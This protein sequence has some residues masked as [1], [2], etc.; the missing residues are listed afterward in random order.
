MEK[1]LANYRVWLESDALTAA[2][3]EELKGIENDET[4]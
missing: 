4:R 2:E 1:Y 3:K